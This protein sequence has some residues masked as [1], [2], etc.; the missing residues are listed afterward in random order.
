MHE[1]TMVALGFLGTL[2][3]VVS[4]ISINIVL[5]KRK[6]SRWDASSTIWF[7]ASIGNFG[8]KQKAMWQRRGGYGRAESEI[9]IRYQLLCLLEMPV[10][11]LLS[12]VLV[13]FLGP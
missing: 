5:V 8:E 4:A 13:P 9:I 12:A 11:L 7:V 6:L 2:A 1:N 10:G 3:G